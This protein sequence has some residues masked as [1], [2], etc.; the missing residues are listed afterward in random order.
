MVEAIANALTPIFAGLLVGYLVGVRKTAAK[1]DVGYLV[2]FLMT[3]ALPCA[4]FLAISHTSRAILKT[5]ITGASVLLATYLAVYV[6]TYFGVGRSAGLNAQDRAV[7]ALT[8]GFPNATAVGIPLLSSVFGPEATVIAAVGI[9]VGAVSI[10]PLTLLI[11]ENG[12]PARDGPRSSSRALDA[13]RKTI[14]RPVVWASLAGV[15]LSLG[16]LK[17]P[18]AVDASLAL[19]GSATAAI[20][21]FVTGRI[22]SA[23]NLKWS[24]PTVVSATLKNVIQPILC[25]GI[26]LWMHRPTTEVRALVLVTSIPCGFFGV[27]FG[28][29]FDCSPALASSTLIGSYVVGVITL[30]C[31]IVFLNGLH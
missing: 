5:Q 26:L 30:P 29:N 10:S 9:A 14:S 4:L 21:L 6:A 25:L 11:L 23:Q 18:V 3:F 7:L 2:A 24:W 20:A 22:V 27:V 1:Y 12:T 16:A 28:R 17:M 15:G 31:W 8:V 19:F 13:V